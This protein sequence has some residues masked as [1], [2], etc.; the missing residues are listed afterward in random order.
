VVAWRASLEPVFRKEDGGS[1][2]KARAGRW[3]DSTQTDLRIGKT[4][5]TSRGG[6]AAVKVMGGE[7]VKALS[8]CA[9]GRPGGAEAH[10]GRGPEEI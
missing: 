2:R 10:E 5:K 1:G 8:R 4:P 6:F 7:G 3:R 9:G